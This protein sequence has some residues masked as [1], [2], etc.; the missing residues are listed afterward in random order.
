MAELLIGD[1]I[2]VALFCLIQS[3]SSGEEGKS[4]NPE[5]C[6]GKLVL[7]FV[8]HIVVVVVCLFTMLL[9]SGV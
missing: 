1:E 8:Y 2:E 5:R 4:G 6:K 7:L 3:P 9:F